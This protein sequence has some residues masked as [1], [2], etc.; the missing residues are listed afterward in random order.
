MKKE[1]VYVPVN[2]KKQAKQYKAILEGLGEVVK[3][4]YF[5]NTNLLNSHLDFRD[6][7]W[8]LGVS[9]YKQKITIKQ[10]IEIL[11]NRK[12]E[13]K[14]LEVG[15]WY[16]LNFGVSFINFQGHDIKAYGFNY[17][18]GWTTDFN[19]DSTILTYNPTLATNEEVKQALT[20]EAI[21]RGFKDGF[22]ILK[23]NKLFWGDTC[24]FDNGKWAAVKKSILDG[25]VAIQVNN[26]MER[27]AV[28]LY[29]KNKI[30][31]LRRGFPLF[32]CLDG[33]GFHATAKECEKHS[34]EVVQF[35]DFAKE[36]GIKVP[37]F[38]MKSEDGVDLYDVDECYNVEIKNGIASLSKNLFKNLFPCLSSSY[39]ITRPT[40]YKAFH[41][42]ENALKWIEEQNKPKSKTIPL[43]FGQEAIINFD[44][45]EV[46]IMDGDKEVSTLSFQDIKHLHNQI[47]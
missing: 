14:E 29:C 42:K 46:R 15:K 41:S 25:K 39:F 23:E 47:S 3:E 9:G 40:E 6:N 24:V 19:A 2:G 21:N 27:D 35:A 28:N 12:E 43:Y 1:N 45:V 20:K 37:V 7:G 16:K 4:D 8:I 11:V 36:V 33:S 34:D 26:G 5:T 30:T 38:V 31:S 17:Y 32:I 18:R 13:P 10:L 44:K 22:Y